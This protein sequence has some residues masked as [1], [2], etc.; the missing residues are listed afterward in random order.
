[1]VSAW[2]AAAIQYVKAASIMVAFAAAVV[3]LIE[4]PEDDNARPEKTVP[5]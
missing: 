1:V 5:E 2:L 4:G 3:I